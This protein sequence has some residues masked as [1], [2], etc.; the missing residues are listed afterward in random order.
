VPPYRLLRASRETAADLAEEPLALPAGHADVPGE[1]A[2]QLDVLLG[3]IDPRP[4]VLA[5]GDDLEEPA[6]LDLGPVVG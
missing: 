5:D 2:E 3:V 1:G 4:V 6:R